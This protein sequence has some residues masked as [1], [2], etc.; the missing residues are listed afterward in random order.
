M[1]GRR[2]ST[3][4]VTR[5]LMAQIAHPSGD[6][7]MGEL[8]PREVE[9]VRLI[10]QG[11]SNHEIGETLFITEVTVRTHVSNLLSKLGLASR[12]Q[13]ALWALRHGIASLDE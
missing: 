5:K 4:L 3:R 6:T 12:T 2:R 13:A 7:G 9:V 1:P 8:T 11:C 10:A